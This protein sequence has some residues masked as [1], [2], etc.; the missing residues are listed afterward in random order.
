MTRRCRRGSQRR[1]PTQG[2]TN[3]PQR[4]QPGKGTFPSSWVQARIF[5][6]GTSRPRFEITRFFLYVCLFVCFFAPQRQLLK[7]FPIT[8]PDMVRSRATLFLGLGKTRVRLKVTRRMRAVGQN[9][10][11]VLSK[12]VWD[13]YPRAS[14]ENRP[15][16]ERVAATETGHSSSPTPFPLGTGRVVRRGR[17]CSQNEPPRNIRTQAG[18]R[19]HF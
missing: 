12:L 14:G 9:Q 4:G 8:G 2:R 10:R 5:P 15:R 7:S 6:Q 11:R 16:Y 13:H 3:R 17:R 19:V 18:A 1:R